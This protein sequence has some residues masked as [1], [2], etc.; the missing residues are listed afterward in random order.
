MLHGLLAYRSSIGWAHALEALFALAAVGGGLVAMAR[1]RR[2]DAEGRWPLVILLTVWALPFATCLAMSLL[3][4]KDLLYAPRFFALFAPAGIALLG[5]TISWVDDGPRLGRLRRPLAVVLLA[6]ALIPQAGSM[7]FLF[8]GGRARE[9]FPIDEISAYLKQHSRPQDVAIIHHSYY[10]LFFDHYYHAPWP[11]FQGAVQQRYDPLPLG[12]LYDRATPAAV[13]DALQR[14]D[15]YRR[16]WLILTPTT[17]DAWRD[18]D[19]LIERAFDRRFKLRSRRC[20]SCDSGD[21]VVLKLYLP[22]G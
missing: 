21:P 13:R 9:N 6:A 14:V 2:G 22:R 15:G 4:S 18:P 1:V 19:R 12:G 20:F 7:A 3:I 8:G 10:Q 5:A 16:I 17:N 11:R